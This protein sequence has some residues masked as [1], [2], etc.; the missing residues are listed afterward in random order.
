MSILEAGRPNVYTKLFPSPFGP[1]TKLFM[2]MDSS[3][4][5]PDGK[6]PPNTEPFWSCMA[7]TTGSHD[8]DRS[9]RIANVDEPSRRKEKLR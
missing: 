2:F 1:S 3:T 9:S 8:L 5:R 7:I 4:Y 6:K